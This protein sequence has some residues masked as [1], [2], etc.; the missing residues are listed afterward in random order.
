MLLCSS[1][2]GVKV[3]VWDREVRDNGCLLDN[4]L[5]NTE[6]ARGMGIF[7]MMISNNR[8]GSYFKCLLGIS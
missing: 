3:G 8:F 5:C 1:L 6:L 2:K 4:E 7:K